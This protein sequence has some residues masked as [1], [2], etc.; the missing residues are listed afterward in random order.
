MV[1]DPILRF[2]WIFYMIFANDVQHSALLSFVISFS[3]ICRRGMWTLFRVENE[4]CTNVGRFRA[5]R[6]VP[7]PFSLTESSQ[8]SLLPSPEVSAEGIAPDDRRPPTRTPTIH[9]RDTQT[10]SVDLEQGDSAG[11]RR[12][13]KSHP[14]PMVR[15]L[16]NLAIQMHHA[17]VQD[18]ERKKVPEAGDEEYASSDDGA[19][20][21]EQDGTMTEEVENVEDEEALDIAKGKSQIE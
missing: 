5:S 18:F 2:N 3:E 11:M 8:T 12:R 17:H 4:H 13:A 14:S 7:L 21:E 16:S 19:M 6:D 20:D 15:G 9:R 1:V 10:S